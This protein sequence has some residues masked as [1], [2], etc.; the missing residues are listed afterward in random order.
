MAAAVCVSFGARAADLP[1]PNAPLPPAPS[2]PVSDPWSG[3]WLGVYGGYG[4]AN[5]ASG[6]NVT[7]DPTDVTP[8]IQSQ[9]NGSGNGTISANGFL[10]GV[11]GGW[12]LRLNTDFVVGLEADVGY[13][14]VRGGRVAGDTIPAPYNAPYTVSEHVSTDWQAALRARGG[15]LLNPAT[16]LFVEGGPA[17]GGV[18]Y[19]GS[20]GDYIPAANYNEIESASGSAVKVGLSL[21]AGFEYLIGPNLS[22]RAEYLYTRFPS[23]NMTGTSNMLLPVPAPG[24]VAHSSGAINQQAVRIGINYLFR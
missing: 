15:Y 8:A 5:P 16:L 19:G 11:Q 1:S 14:G 9:V 24:Y 12:N 13:A 7:G 17:L 20:F 4:F 21:G 22:L 6:F 3:P 10:G 2:V 18:R 23:V